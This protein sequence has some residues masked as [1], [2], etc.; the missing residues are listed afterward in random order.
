VP[1]AANS[2]TFDVEGGKLV[3]TDNGTPDDMT[4]F[5]SAVRKAFNGLA[6]AI[7]R[8][9]AGSLGV[10]KVSASGDGLQGDTIT[11]KLV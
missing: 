8:A 7:V 1:E 10:I 4:P 5:P 6:L 3:A 9:H 11:V 2:I